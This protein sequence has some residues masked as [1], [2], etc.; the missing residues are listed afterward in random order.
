[1]TTEQVLYGSL[2]EAS[3]DVSPRL[4]DPFR[5]GNL[6]H[7]AEKDYD[8]HSYNRENAT[9]M[10]QNRPFQEEKSVL[11]SEGRGCVH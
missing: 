11:G 4:P 6:T 10:G 7:K 3:V 5:G 8:T 9:E 1:M 2:K